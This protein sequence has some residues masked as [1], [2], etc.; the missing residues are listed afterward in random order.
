[1]D[2]YKKQ[3]RNRNWLEFSEKIKN[4]DEYK[5][6]KCGRTGIVLQVHHL[7]YKT[8]LKIWEYPLSDC[9]TLCKS[10]HAVEHGIIEPN[11][12][13][14][15]ISITDNEDYGSSTCERRNCNHPIRHE[16]EVYHPKFGYMIVGSSC[17]DFLTE[18]DKIINSYITKI[19]NGIRRFTKKSEWSSGKTKKK[20]Q[21]FFIF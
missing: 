7:N 20:R 1:M 9:I 17:V 4:R 16:Y 13:W 6:G 15:L 19:N 21:V 12:G 8:N 18:D 5:C 11:S 3:Y 2:N 10:C 14:T